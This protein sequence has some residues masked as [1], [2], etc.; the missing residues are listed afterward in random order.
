MKVLLFSISANLYISI[1]A[2]VAGGVIWW[3]VWVFFGV[4]PISV[5]LVT[6]L[7]GYVLASIV[8]NASPLGKIYIFTTGRYA[9]LLFKPF[10]I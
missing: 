6:L 10:L 1:G 5:A 4:P 9:H 7:L 3:A 8:F 2:G